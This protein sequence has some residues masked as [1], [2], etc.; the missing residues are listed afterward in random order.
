MA[1]GAK[2]E[3][4]VVLVVA[5]REAKILGVANFSCKT[6]FL[7][8]LAKLAFIFV[9]AEMATQEEVGPR[10]VGYS[11]LSQR[12]GGGVTPPSLRGLWGA[13]CGPRPRLTNDPD[14]I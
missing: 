5:S 13:R 2:E 14:K 6:V 7:S 9:F 10:R 4:R 12:K 3:A 1:L 8:K 11:Q